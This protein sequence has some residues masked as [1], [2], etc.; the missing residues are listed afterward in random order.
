MI[1]CWT[2][3]MT[4]L[5]HTWLVVHGGTCLQFNL[6]AFISLIY[7]NVCRN[8]H[9][10]LLKYSK[11]IRQWFRHLLKKAKIVVSN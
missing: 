1:S 6:I 3:F 11:I 2:A 9:L 4:V 5:D 7:L 10:R 8:K